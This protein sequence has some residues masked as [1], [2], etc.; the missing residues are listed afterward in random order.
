ML[1]FIL[2]TE[3]LIDRPSCVK[4]HG[5]TGL[6]NYSYAKITKMTNLNNKVLTIIIYKHNLD[7]T[8]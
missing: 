1:Y 7:T 2:H 6:H 3:K 4:P 5:T 8:L